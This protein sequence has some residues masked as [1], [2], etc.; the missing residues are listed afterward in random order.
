MVMRN[1]RTL[2]PCRGRGAGR[3]CTTGGMEM[4]LSHG[5]ASAGAAC[6]ALRYGMR[7]SSVRAVLVASIALAAACHAGLAPSPAAVP[8][9]GA[10]A[11]QLVVVT[12]AGWD[13]P[14][15]AL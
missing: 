14:T 3:G 12:T 11:T 15:G 1:R 8:A 5:S 4:D 9:D 10:A 7:R 2:S 13:S 6:D